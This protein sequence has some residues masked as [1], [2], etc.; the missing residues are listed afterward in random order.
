MTNIPKRLV[1]ATRNKGKIREVRE[2][3]GDLE[4]EFLTLDDLG[5]VPEVEEDGKTFLDN[6][7]KKAKEISS[8]TGLPALSDDS[9]LEVDRLDGDPGVYS[10][11]FAGP[12]A[13]DTDRYEKLLSLLG[14]VPEDER[15]ARFRCAVALASPDCEIITAEGSC[16]GR[17]ADRPRGSGGFGYDP[18]FISSDL[19]ITFAEASPELKNSVSHRRRALLKLKEIL[20]RNT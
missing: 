15:G 6:A 12:N 7:V 16:D 1:L 10:A 11:R 3:L 14:G 9:G 19:G 4:I 18:V 5:P 20:E 8:Y 2:I 17:I 13:S